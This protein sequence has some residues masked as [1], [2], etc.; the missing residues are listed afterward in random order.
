VV[1][2]PAIV[3]ADE[4]TGSLDTRTGEEIIELLLELNAAGATLVVITHDAGV[5]AHFPRR[6]EM[7][8]G[9]IVG[10]TAV[11]TA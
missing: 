9:R 8:D 2:E 6:V 11:V 3:F 1:G 10:D 4:P 5:A 7:L